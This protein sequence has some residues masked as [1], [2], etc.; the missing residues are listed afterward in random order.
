[1]LGSQ[2]LAVEES[3]LARTFKSAITS[4][5]SDAYRYQILSKENRSFPDNSY[6]PRDYTSKQYCAQISYN[7]SKQKKPASSAYFDEGRWEIQ[8]RRYYE[9]LNI[10]I[11]LK[12]P[13]DNDLK[14]YVSILIYKRG[15]GIQLRLRRKA[16]LLRALEASVRSNSLVGGVTSPINNQR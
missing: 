12:K 13:L 15:G 8:P 7:P 2:L 4:F 9:T 5:L 6:L 1:M 14:V 16:C 3:A 10:V 11:I